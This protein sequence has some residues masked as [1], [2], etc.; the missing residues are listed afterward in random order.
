VARAARSNTPAVYRR[1]R[2]RRDL[3]RA[4]VRRSQ[5]EI[6][7]IL[8][9]CRSVEEAAEAYLQFALRRPY[10]YDLFYQHLRELVGP[11]RAGRALSEKELRPNLA[12]MERKM[13][14]QVGGVPEDHTRFV[15]VLAA[16]AHGTATF[17]NAQA[18]PPGQ[19]E[20]MRSAFT[21]AVAAMLQDT[22]R[23]ALG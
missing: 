5:Q 15:L 20:A 16:L 11:A 21:A 7:G 13:A 23:S 17:L 2:N 6:T 9:P 19:E 3:V 8:Q 22:F 18:V 12:L 14:D 1:F 10:E 4:L